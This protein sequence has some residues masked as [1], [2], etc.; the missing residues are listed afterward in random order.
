MKKKPSRKSK[1][2][3][4]RSRLRRKGIMVLTGRN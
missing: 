1:N 4:E 2:E 3:E